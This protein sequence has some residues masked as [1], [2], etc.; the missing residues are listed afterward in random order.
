M[1][2]R[3]QNGSSW[4]RWL[5]L[6]AT[7]VLTLVVVIV[8][9][10][11]YL[12][13]PALPD[14]VPGFAARKGELVSAQELRRTVEGEDLIVETR[15]QSSS[16]LMVDIG[17]RTPR[18]ATSKLP[19]VVLLGGLRTGHRA[20]YLTKD[21]HGIAIAALS[22]PFPGNPRAT[23]LEYVTWL[24]KV[25]TALIDVTPAVM[26]AMDYLAQQPH[27]DLARVDLV[28]G[29][30]GAFMV[31]VPASFD[32]RFKRVWLVHGAGDPHGVFAHLLTPYITFTPLR[33]LTAQLLVLI[34][35]S[36]HLRPEKW[37]GRI[38]P[39]PVIAVNA[40]DDES[41]PPASVAA[42]HQALPPGSE[43]IWTEGPHVRP[44]RNAVLEGLIALVTERVRE[45]K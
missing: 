32:T 42:L 7:L 27:V 11:V 31:S 1:R 44:G 29:S 12:V 35:A 40:R 36:H 39:R 9:A 41:M 4:P 26:L 43:V 22:Y 38:A 18:A 17:V 33:D 30:L 2:H 14:P 5:K 15:L 10:L 37:V 16:G 23:G 20:V 24:P 8:G 21:A 6:I 19:L 13:A 28:G 34:T 25:Q 3:Q 45:T